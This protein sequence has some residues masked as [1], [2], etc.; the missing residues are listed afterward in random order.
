MKLKVLILSFLIIL[1]AGCSQSSQTKQL[2]TMEKEQMKASSDY[3]D[4]G[5]WGEA[6]SQI[7]DVAPFQSIRTEGNV[8][9]VYMQSKECSVKAFGNTKAIEQYV[10]HVEEGKSLLEIKLKDYHYDS[11]GNFDEHIPG[12]T[13][14]VTSPILEDVH[15]Y[16]EGDVEIKSNIRQQHDLCINVSGR[17]DVDAK[18]VEALGLYIN[19]DGK[20]DVKLK[21]AF[22]Q[23][24][25]N[26]KLDGDG[27]VN[28]KVECANTH[29]EVN[30]RGDV[31]LNVKCNE[32]TAICNGMG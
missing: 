14:F 6:S 28:A 3:R 26:F 1:L 17:G 5:E 25:A 2:S 9:I 21:K 20:G 7:I 8:E 11:A 19:I 31:K 13:V 29:I 18:E 27:D 23:G 24:N 30:G 15:V 12:I 32:L 22:C 10:F 16:G 4:S